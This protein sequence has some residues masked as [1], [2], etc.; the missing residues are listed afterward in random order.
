MRRPRRSRLFPYTTL[1]RS[2][3]AG[4]GRRPAVVE[5]GRPHPRGA[6]VQSSLPRPRR[7]DRPHPGQPRPGALR[8]RRRRADRRSRPHPLDRGRPE[9]TA[10]RGG[11]GPPPRRRPD[12]RL[13]AAPRHRGLAGP[14]RSGG[15]RSSPAETVEVGRTA[16]EDSMARQPDTTR[17]HGVITALEQWSRQRLRRARKRLKLPQGNAVVLA[18]LRS[19]AHRLLSASAVELR[20]T[21]VRSGRPYV[22]PV[23]YAGAGDELVVWP[24]HWQRST[25]WRNFRTPQPVTVRLTGRLHEGKIGRASCRERV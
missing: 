7:A 17:V 13:T 3:P 24:Q 6:A 23:Q 11:L 14:G 10:G 12:R 8:G 25:W 19:R 22:L 20:Y 4:P 9:P 5:P 21:G 15:R 2:P 1:F 18:V 16:E